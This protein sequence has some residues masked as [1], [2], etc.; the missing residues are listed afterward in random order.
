MEQDGARGSFHAEYPLALAEAD[1]MKA[2]YQ[3][4]TTSCHHVLGHA[5]FVK[6]EWRHPQRKPTRRVQLGPTHASNDITDR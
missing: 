5:N 2:W 4:L 3:S 1:Q 6:T